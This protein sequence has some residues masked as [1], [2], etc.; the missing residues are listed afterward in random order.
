MTIT[1]IRTYCTVAL[2]VSA[3]ILIALERFFP[4]DKGQKIFRGHFFNDFVY[5][6]LIQS[7][8]LGM[9][10]SYV[11]Q[12]FDGA[13]G[14][15]RLHIVSSWGI[16][17]QLL[18]FFVIHDCYI[19][20]FHRFQHHSKYFWRLHEAHHSTEDVD[21]LSGTR[22]HSIEIF[23]NQGIEFGVILCL[24]GSPEVAVLKGLIDGIWGMYIHSNINVHSGWLQKIINGPEMHRWHH[25]TDSD[26]Q[27]K[28]FSTKLAI[29]DW[30]FGTAFLPEARKPKAYGL[31][32]PTFPDQYID[33]HFYAFR[34]QEK[35]EANSEAELV[36]P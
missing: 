6:A 9:I 29:W 30:M 21:W 5:Y 1:E 18:F 26:A 20:W 14:L 11:I 31:G 27:N 32:D 25:A 12:W 16:G 17:W 24:G 35:E 33:Q 23:I 10:I 3:V 2:V 13:T 22:S 8:V 15:S 4:Y 36:L 28:N 7:Y 34:P 19:Y